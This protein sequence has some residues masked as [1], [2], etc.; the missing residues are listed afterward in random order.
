MTQDD[1]FKKLISH[2][3]EYGFVFPPRNLRW[4]ERRV[5]YGQNGVALKE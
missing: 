5:D 2:G 3:K 1:L 4:F